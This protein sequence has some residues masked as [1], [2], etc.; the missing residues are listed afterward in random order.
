MNENFVGAQVIVDIYTF[1]IIPNFYDLNYIKKKFANVISSLNHVVE[2]IDTK[3]IN[4][5]DWALFLY[6]DKNLMSFRTYP[7][8]YI[9]ISN[10]YTNCDNLTK[11][12]LEMISEVFVG[13]KFITRKICRGPKSILTYDC[14]YIKEITK[15]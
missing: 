5:N 11:K 4:Q 15:K 10:L 7:E 14:D 2:D 13:C 8:D 6:F 9:I 1:D 3:I 12:Y